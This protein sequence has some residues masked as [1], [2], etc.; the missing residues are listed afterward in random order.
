MIDEISQIGATLGLDDKDLENAFSGMSSD[1]FFSSKDVRKKL[2]KEVE[3]L[4]KFKK[5]R[6]ADISILTDE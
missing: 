5:D 2:E 3:N 6:L 1:E 4:S